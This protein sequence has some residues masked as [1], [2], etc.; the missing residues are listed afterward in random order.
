MSFAKKRTSVGLAEKP[1][2]LKSL[3]DTSVTSPRGSNWMKSQSS[4]FTSLPRKRS[5]L[6]LMSFYRSFKESKS[7]PLPVSLKSCAP[8]KEAATST[9]SA[10]AGLYKKRP[11]FC[12]PSVVLPCIFAFFMGRLSASLFRRVVLAP[13]AQHLVSPK[14]FQDNLPV[15]SFADVFDN[16]IT[17]ETPK[18]PTFKDILEEQKSE[19]L[20]RHHYDHYYDKW[21]K[22]YRLEKD[23]KVLE[24]GARNTDTLL[25]WPKYF[26]HAPALI[27]GLTVGAD[28]EGKDNL[29]RGVASM[30]GDPT[31]VETLNV[32]RPKG[33][34]DII[35]DDGSH[36]PG[37]MIT[38]LYG[39]WSSLKPGGTYIIEGLDSS[40]YRDGEEVGNH[41]AITGAGIGS[42][43]HTS[44]TEKLKQFLDVMVR[45][46][47]GAFEL[48]IMPGD[49]NLCA[50][51]W[52]RN[53]VALN[54]CNDDERKFPPVFQRGRYDEDKMAVWLKEARASNP[55]VSK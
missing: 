28:M 23:M 26:Y 20:W 19:K 17:G 10:C 5:S 50:I 7:F 36:I 9:V 38:T 42:T 8:C 2:T 29:P 15:P 14:A 55:D 4:P 47:I 34:F 22:P 11:A 45:S 46:H 18:P 16:L 21:F 37:H 40:Y 43:P 39:L 33:P 27:Q 53:I 48:S 41:V 30:Q 3:S 32:I 13:A 52:G 12:T 1:L 51:N 49:D 35:I 54:K 6:P 24:I 44:A 31:S 25:K